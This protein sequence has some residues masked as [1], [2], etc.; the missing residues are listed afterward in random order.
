MTKLNHYQEAPMSENP[1]V[2]S[3]A[4]LR[5]VPASRVQVECRGPLEAAGV[6]IPFRS[7]DSRIPAN[8]DVVCHLSLESYVGGVMVAGTIRAEWEGLCSRCTLPVAG[9]LF[10]PVR[11]RF[12]DRAAPGA[13]D[14]EDAY[15]IEDDRIDLEPMLLDALVPELPL[16]PLCR[17]DCAGLCQH[18]GTDRNEST[19]DCVA[20]VD[21][22]WANLDVLRSS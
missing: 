3:V 6:V 2:V 7:A 5:R 14:D 4:R 10:V 16:A 9:E 21:P 17:G 18:C 20:P 19:C 8:T 12:C 13:K 15:P 22:R 1:F 11:E